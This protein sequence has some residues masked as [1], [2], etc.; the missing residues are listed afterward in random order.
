M[1]LHA[2]NPGERSRFGLLGPCMAWCK[3]R[4]V[5]RA[6]IRVIAVRSRIDNGSLTNLLVSN[7][8]SIDLHR[9]ADRAC[10]AGDP[11]IV[12]CGRLIRQRM[13]ANGYRRACRTRAVFET[14]ERSTI[15]G[16]F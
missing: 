9:F 11:V 6:A 8:S 10:T 15:A 1:V 2:G 3:S 5:Q 7:R 14:L 12:T 16:Q 13:G 4:P